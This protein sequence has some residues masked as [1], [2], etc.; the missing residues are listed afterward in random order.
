MVYVSVV[1]KHEV[2][3]AFFFQMTAVG[4]GTLADFL[5]EFRR[6]IIG[7]VLCDRRVNVFDLRSDDV[8]EADQK[9]VLDLLHRLLLVGGEDL[10]R[11]SEILR[12]KR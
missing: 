10:L 6:Q 3:L 9:H 8:V 5:Q 1:Q 2:Y 4:Q 7:L 12:V 11:L